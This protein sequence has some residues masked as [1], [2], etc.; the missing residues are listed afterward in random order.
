MSSS[1]NELLASPPKQL[2]DELTTVREER[3]RAESTEEVILRMIDILLDSGGEAADWLND[4]AN[5]AMAIG[6]LRRQIIWAMRTRPD[7]L[8]IPRN[9]ADVLEAA[10]GRPSIDNVRMTMLRMANDG[11]LSQPDPAAPAFG[12]FLPDP[13]S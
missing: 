2:L 12:L 3:L 5:G 6:P 11:Q 10:G 8:W 7:E 4:P 13:A 9:V 1:I